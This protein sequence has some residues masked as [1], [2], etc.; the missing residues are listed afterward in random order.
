MR[1]RLLRY[2]RRLLWQRRFVVGVH[3]CMELST[4][5]LV[6]SWQLPW[7]FHFHRDLHRMSSFLYSVS[8]STEDAML[9]ALGRGGWLRLAQYEVIR[10]IVSCLR[11]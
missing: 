1:V 10:R 2:L 4:W 9:T 3:Y 11:E 8:F 6:V 5:Y 7:Y